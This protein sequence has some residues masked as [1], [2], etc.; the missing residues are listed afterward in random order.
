K[1]VHEESTLIQVYRKCCRNIERNFHLTALTSHHAPPNMEKTYQKMA[2]YLQENGPNE[3]HPGRK[4]AYIIPDIINQG[5]AK[6]NS[7]EKTTE[8]ENEEA[9]DR[10]AEERPIEREDMFDT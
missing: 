9:E 6:M 4:T 3:H 2:K 5:Q 10:D 8:D 7:N 1:R